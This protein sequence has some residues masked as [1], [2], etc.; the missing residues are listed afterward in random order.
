VASSGDRL[1]RNNS[2][3]GTEPMAAARW[4]GYWPRMSLIRVDAG[5]EAERSF[6][7]TGR[8]RLEAVKWRAV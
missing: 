6:R 2:T 1:A 8:L 3:K 7:A 5:G 4:M